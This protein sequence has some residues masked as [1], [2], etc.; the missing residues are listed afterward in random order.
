M[1]QQWNEAT[2]DSD[3]KVTPV[4]K[5]KKKGGGIGK[6]LPLLL[7]GG[8]LA[9]LAS[10]SGLF[11]GGGA[12]CGKGKVPSSGCTGASVQQDKRK[13]IAQAA[14]GDLKAKSVLANA[15]VA[16][17]NQNEIDGLKSVPK[18]G[19]ISAEMMQMLTSGSA[20]GAKAGDMMAQANQSPTAATA[21]AQLPNLQS[22]VNNPL[23]DEMEDE[24]R[25]Q[26]FDNMM[27]M[28][29]NYGQTW[30]NPIVPE[31]EKGWFGW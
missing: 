25:K 15:P 20:K 2:Y 23:L 26:F 16:S 1:A 7:G 28:G 22:V 13:A 4:D 30:Q 29:R 18:P 27:N 11:G 5:K 8:A 24:E 12:N 31:E 21:A 6:L 17:G 9:L 14:A 10:K 19:V 3:G